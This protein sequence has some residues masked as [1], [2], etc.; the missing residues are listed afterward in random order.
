MSVSSVSDSS[1]SLVRALSQRVD[2]DPAE[3]SSADQLQPRQTASPTSNATSP[4]REPS[5]QRAAAA[6]QDAAAPRQVSR[7][8]VAS[9]FDRLSGP[10]RAQLLAVQEQS[11]SPRPDDT[12]AATDSSTQTETA[13]PSRNTSGTTNAATSTTD[14]DTDR[15]RRDARTETRADTR[16]EQT[17]DGSTRRAEASST[18]STTASSASETSETGESSETSESSE[19]TEQ[20][21]AAT[22]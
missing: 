20:A 4:A 2:R 11:A 6:G 21:R 5:T 13:Q 14:S 22:A 15:E 1:S 19:T 8:D 17:G 18:P 7:S 16:T 12:A 3:R 9:T 10:V